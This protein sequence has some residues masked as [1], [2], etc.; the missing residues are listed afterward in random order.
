MARRLAGATMASCTL[1]L[2]WPPSVN[3]WWDPALKTNRRTGAHYMTL[4]RSKQAEAYHEIVEWVLIAQRLDR[5]A[6]PYCQRVSLTLTLTPPQ[7]SNGNELDIDNGLKGILDVLQANGIL[8]NDKL[9]RELHVTYA[10]PYG[11]GKV[12]VEIAPLREE[13]RD[14]TY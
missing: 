5:T 7:R 2:P 6:W 14:A 11:Q 8:Q 9:V 10:V 4:K 3:N 13:D 12:L 1:E